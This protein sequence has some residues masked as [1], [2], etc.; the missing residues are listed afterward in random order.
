RSLS[1]SWSK[2]SVDELSDELDESD[3]LEE[4]DELDDELSQLPD[5]PEPPGP[6]GP[7]APPGPPGPP[8]PP[9]PPGPPPPPAPPGPLAKVLANRFCSSVAW[10][11]VSAPLCT[12]DEIRLLIFDVMSD[13]DGGDEDDDAS[14]CSDESMLCNAVLNAL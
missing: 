10:S 12:C 7:P 9:E 13:C 4:L 2:V 8:G 11:L 6:P 3:E 1:R 14:L 5:P